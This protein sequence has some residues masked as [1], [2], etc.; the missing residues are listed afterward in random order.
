MSRQGGLGGTSEQG[1]VGETSGQGG[2]RNQTEDD[3]ESLERDLS[4]V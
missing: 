2:A 3:M 4:E 1:G